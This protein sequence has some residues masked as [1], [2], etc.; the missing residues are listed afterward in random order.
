MR[1]E[2]PDLGCGEAAAPI[3]DGRGREIARRYEKAVGDMNCIEFARGR[4]HGG[5]EL[6]HRFRRLFLVPQRYREYAA[7]VERAHVAE[8]GLARVGELLH[9]REAAGVR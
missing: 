2:L 9:D 7:V 1:A 6:E 5:V 3:E 8:H 4:R